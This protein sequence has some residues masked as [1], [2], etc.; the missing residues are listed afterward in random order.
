MDT[1]TSALSISLLCLGALFFSLWK[2]RRQ[3]T[4]RT[5]LPPGPKGLPWVGN[6]LD[7]DASQPW[8][9]YEEWGKRYGDLTYSRVLGKEY[10]IVNSEKVAHELLDQRSSIYSDR[11]RVPSVDL[12]GL[13]FTTP[14]L[15]YGEEWRR[16]R[17]ALHLVLNKK[18]SLKYGTMHLQRAHGL[19]ANLLA[20][21]QNYE[22]HFAMFS[23]A[24]IMELAYG[25]S[26]T[27]EKDPFM[28]NIVQLLS[29]VVEVATPERSALLGAFPFLAHIPSWMPGGFWKKRANDC[30]QLVKKVL[31]DPVQYVRDSMVAG[32]AKKS[33]VRDI[34][35]G[36]EEDL[37]LG[38]DKERVTKEVA[39]SVF[40]AGSE[41][42]TSAMLVFLLAMV[43][44]P[45]VQRKAQEE[46][47]RVVGTDRLPDFGDR[48]NLPYVEAVL[49]ETI[50]WI[51]VSALGF[52]H[53]TTADDTYNGMYIPKGVIII[54]NVWA[55]TQDPV[56]YPEPKVFNPD[57][58]GGK[59]E[60]VALSPAFGFGRRVCPGNHLAE[61]SLWA[62]VVSMLATMQIGKATDPS[63]VEIEVTPRL[64]SGGAIRPETFPC[65]IKVRSS[66]AEHLIRAST[67]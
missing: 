24:L 47:D 11:P 56:R 33:M 57:R 27:S 8:V 55:M 64:K 62:V 14:T 26:V 31:D 60:D 12:L 59:L 61:Q 9:T 45:D 28:D 20:T 6:V 22:D 65:S 41:T 37:D 25:Y 10:I 29:L 36:K 17:K 43:L 51:P 49:L 7:I 19:L 50:R 52:P 39:A 63:G 21:P 38:L 2:S 4:S 42:T 40:M 13:G 67:I 66:K 23:V 44:Q 46:I 16:H 3:R 30:R 54:P 18:E 32:T 53:T 35:Q 5:F 48:P 58:Y 15:P 1:S 34:F